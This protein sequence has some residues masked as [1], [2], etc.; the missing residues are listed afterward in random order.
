MLLHP[1]GVFRSSQAQDQNRGT[2][3]WHSSWFDL[4]RANGKSSGE[5]CRTYGDRG[6]TGLL[7]QH[8]RQPSTAE[9]APPPRDE[10]SPKFRSPERIGNMVCLCEDNLLPNI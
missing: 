4:S 2:Q 1:Q 5:V 9:R 3:V 8:T 10:W 7:G 6:A